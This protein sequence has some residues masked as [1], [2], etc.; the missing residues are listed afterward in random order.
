MHFCLLGVL[1]CKDFKNWESKYGSKVQIKFEEKKDQWILDKPEDLGS[2]KVPDSFLIKIKKPVYINKSF[3]LE[4]GLDI[5]LDPDADEVSFELEDDRHRYYHKVVICY[6][7]TLSLISHEA[8]GLQVQYTIKDIKLIPKDN[9]KAIFKEYKI[10]NPIPL[11][12]EKAQ[13]HVTLYY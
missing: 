1:S 7:R 3:K 5:Q 9:K 10:E 13:T 2:I 8:G 11:K 4:N 6:K 12:E